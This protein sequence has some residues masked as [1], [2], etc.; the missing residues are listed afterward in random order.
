VLPP[1][2]R[3]DVRKSPIAKQ[4]LR[5]ANCGPGRGAALTILLAEGPMASTAC[6][7]GTR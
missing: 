6:Y 3:I 4:S 5:K 1:W 7:S 2:Y